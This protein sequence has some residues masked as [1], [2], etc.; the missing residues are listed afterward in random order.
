[1]RYMP[2]PCAR[3]QPG[4]FEGQTQGLL[5]QRFHGLPK[6]VPK[7]AS[8]SLSQRRTPLRRLFEDQTSNIM[9]DLLLPQNEIRIISLWQ[10]WA[11]WVMLGWKTIETRL[12]NR[13]KS[14]AGQRIGI[15][16]ANTWDRL[17]FDSAGPY[18]SEDQRKQ[19]LELLG[20]AKRAGGRL[21][22]TVHVTGAHWLQIEDSQAALIGCYISRFGLFLSDPT[23]L[24]APIIM[25]GKQGIWRYKLAA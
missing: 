13:F 18:L 24:P 4:R 14:L 2:I 9:T 23:P 11:Q 5:R 19:T 12:H 7:L 10:P 25:R 20:N 3:N 21:L 22:G 15:H 1:M 6:D 8:G 17:C 16:A